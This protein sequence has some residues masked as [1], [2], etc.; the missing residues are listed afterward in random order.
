MQFDWAAVPLLPGLRRADSG[1]CAWLDAPRPEGFS[2]RAVPIIV[3]A[4]VRKAGQTCTAGSR[5]LVQGSIFD[6]VAGHVGEA[7]TKVR[8]GMPA[9]DFDCGPA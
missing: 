5:L 9:M 1:R 3:R 4:I 7:F 6:C 8:V 2:T